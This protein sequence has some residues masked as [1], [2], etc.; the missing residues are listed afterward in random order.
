MK[1][2]TAPKA[3]CMRDKPAMLRVSSLHTELFAALES[4][5]LLRQDELANNLSEALRSL[6]LDQKV[7]G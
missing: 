2:V 4:Q 3:K 7:V 5:G 1:Q 6:P